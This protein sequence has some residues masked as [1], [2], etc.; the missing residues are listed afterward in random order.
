MVELTPTQD[1]LVHVSNLSKDYVRDPND[2]VKVGDTL[3]VKVFE[4]D[5][6]G[7]FNL[8]V[9]G[10]EPKAGNG[11]NSRSSAPRGGGDFRPN[12]D[13]RPMAGGPRFRRPER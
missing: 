11:G 2:I 6:Q 8:T 10:V 9:D 3:K 12:R 5:D 1:G 7:R 4:K 13:K